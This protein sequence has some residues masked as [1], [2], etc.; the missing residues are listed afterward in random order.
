MLIGE[1]QH[2]LD[3][4]GRTNFPAKLRDELGAKFYITKGLD[5]CLFVYAEEEWES[6]AQRIRSL[7]MSKSR[8]LQRFFF[9]G[10][11][12][13]QP[14]KQGRV[15]LPANLREYAGLEKEII[16]AGTMNHA[17]IWDKQ[18]WDDRMKSLSPQAIEEVVDSMDF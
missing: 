15:L 11:I 9:G 6:L 1:N 2:S 18:K 5:G 8:D 12:E 14:D 4:K 13:V 17:E 10:A 16:V 3:P 7:P